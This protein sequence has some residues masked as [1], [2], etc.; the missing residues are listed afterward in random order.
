[1]ATSLIRYMLSIAGVAKPALAAAFVLV[2]AGYCTCQAADESQ[3]K[4]EEAKMLVSGFGL[5]KPPLDPVSVKFD[6]TGESVAVRVCTRVTDDGQ[7]C[8]FAFRTI[9]IAPDGRILSISEESRGADKGS[10]LKEESAP[11]SSADKKARRER[12]EAAQE[13]R[14]EALR[15]R[16]AE[17]S[18]GANSTEAAGDR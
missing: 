8:Y 2:C 7:N 13:R 17:E 9:L 6:G 14:R 15:R 4:C 16:R 18:A 12:L 10:V 5:G 3:A 1:M 11:A